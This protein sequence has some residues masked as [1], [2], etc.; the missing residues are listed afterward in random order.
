MSDTA[1]VEMPESVKE[2]VEKIVTTT[3]KGFDLRARLKNR[4]LRKATITLYLDE[5]KGAELG[6]TRD[7]TDGLGNVIGR[8]REGVLG[9]LEAAQEEREDAIHK[10][11]VLAAAGEQLGTEQPPEPDEVVEPNTAEV[12][13]RIAELEKRREEL[14]AE[15]NRDAIVIRMRA[16]PPVIQRDCR[17]K[18][19]AT[20]GIESK[21][22]PDEKIEQYNLAHAAHMMTVMFQSITDNAS[23][24]TNTGIDYDEAIDLMGYLP[25]GQYD[26]LDTMMGQVQYTDAI[27]RSIE[28]QEDFS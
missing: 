13:A 19:K 15:M 25:A 17:R 21:N 3:K 27:S 28:G 1:T 10:H 11:E 6:W 24:E 26:R 4:G 20:L 18:A 22:I 2:E 7:L 9:A 12:D 23:G 8:E 14:V 16:V 5:E